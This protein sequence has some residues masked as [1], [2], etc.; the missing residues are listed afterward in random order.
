M[1]HELQD[2]IDREMVRTMLY[3][4]EQSCLNRVYTVMIALFIGLMLGNICL[5]AIIGSVEVPGQW[6]IA[7]GAAFMVLR[8]VID[9]IVPD[10]KLKKQ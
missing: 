5:M 10:P 8:L 9:Y 3:N 4:A 1:D 2:K 7:Q 6:M